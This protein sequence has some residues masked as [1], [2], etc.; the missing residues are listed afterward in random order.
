[1]VFIN[2]LLPVPPVRVLTLQVDTRRARKWEG[3][4]NKINVSE[5]S[6]SVSSPVMVYLQIGC[7]DINRDI[8]YVH[9]FKGIRFVML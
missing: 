2:I 5:A 7:N 9:V 3:G 1:M 4:E 6:L 8:T